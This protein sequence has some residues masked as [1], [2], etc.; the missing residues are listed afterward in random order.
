MSSY[1]RI[2]NVL[3]VAGCGLALAGAVH[4]ARGQCQANEH[5]RL[6]ALDG[7]SFGASVAISGDLALCEYTGRIL[8]RLEDRPLYYV[9]EERNSSVLLVGEDRVNVVEESRVTDLGSKA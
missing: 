3:V 8:D 4:K 5:V 1:K 9:M 6:S 7:G 2:S